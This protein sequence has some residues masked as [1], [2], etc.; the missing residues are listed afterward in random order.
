MVVQISTFDKLN[1]RVRS[2]PKD[3]SLN[4]ADKFLRHFGYVRTRNNGSHCLY[5]RDGSQTINIQ[6][7]LVKEYQ[8]KIMIDAVDSIEL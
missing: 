3:L 7:P 8:I 6:G 4:E 1:D 5:A 2:F